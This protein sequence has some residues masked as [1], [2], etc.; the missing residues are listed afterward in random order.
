MGLIDLL[1]P[2]LVP[3]KGMVWLGGKIRD[4]AESDLMDKSKIQE[5]LMELQMRYE[6]GEIEEESFEKKETELLERLEAIR[7][8]EQEKRQQGK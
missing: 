2:F 4:M 3:V 1:C 6:M 8:Y 5:K 7:Q